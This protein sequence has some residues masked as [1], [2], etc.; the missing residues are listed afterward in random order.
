MPT[1]PAIKTILR[2]T[3]IADL[4]AITWQ[5]QDGDTG[6]IIQ[7]TSIVFQKTKAQISRE[8]DQNNALNDMP[9]LLISEPFRTDVPVSEGT[10]GTDWWTY[11]F[12]VQLLDT[13]DWD[14]DDRQATW[15]K[16]IQQIISAFR[17]N[18]TTFDTAISAISTSIGK[19]ISVVATGV[20]DVDQSRWVKTGN[21]IAGVLV[22]IRVSQPYGTT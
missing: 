8:F 15:E 3:I 9:G 17:W 13:D 11:E 5:V 21:F 19:L 22:T 4:Q 16:W 1:T 7:P 6:D 12:L 10:I 14:P 18:T 2:N 20:S